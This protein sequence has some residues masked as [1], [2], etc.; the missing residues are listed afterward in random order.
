MVLQGTVEHRLCMERAPGP[1]RILFDGAVAANRA[2][3]ANGQPGPGTEARDHRF[4]HAEF[5][6]FVALGRQ[7]WLE[8][9]YRNGLNYRRCGISVAAPLDYESRDGN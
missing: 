6:G 3:G 5:E 1:K 8:R 9:Q 7:Q 4:G 2:Q